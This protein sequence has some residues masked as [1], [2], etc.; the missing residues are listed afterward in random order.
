MKKILSTLALLV[1]IVTACA[2]TAEPVTAPL[3]DTQVTNPAIS[4]PLATDTA[5]MP[6]S[7]QLTDS[8]LQRGNVFISESGVLLRESFPVQV[9]LTLSG[10]LPT[11]CHQLRVVVSPPDAENK[12]SVDAYTV[13]DPNMLCTQVLKPFQETIELGTFPSGHYTVWVNGSQIAEFDA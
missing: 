7:P 6:I 10:E 5:I 12:I 3:P 4:D 1:V 13:S 11:P 2:P 9:A 8:K